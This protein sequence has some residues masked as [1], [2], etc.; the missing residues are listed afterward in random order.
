[1][2]YDVCLNGA[3]RVK[4]INVEAD[5]MAEAA[6]RAQDFAIAGYQ[7]AQRTNCWPP[8]RDG[9]VRIAYTE[10]QDDRLAP[11][12]LVDRV[13]D[14]DFAESQWFEP[15]Q[16]ADRFV[17]GA[18]DGE[19]EVRRLL[20]L[21]SAHLRATTRAALDAEP[22]HYPVQAATEYGWYVYVPA[23]AE[24]HAEPDKKVQE[25]L[26]EVIRFA[27]ERGFH[28]IK[29][30]CDAEVARGLPIYEDV[31]PGETHA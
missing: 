29:I 15:S 17:P 26:L 20:V 5:S 14:E 24:W 3:L 7:D 8:I 6:I 9:R 18:K 2:L 27:R 11:E 31:M 12:A 22:L 23:E 4:V 30:D 10:I 1:M 28:E 13:G 25:D 19:L 21:S 16:E